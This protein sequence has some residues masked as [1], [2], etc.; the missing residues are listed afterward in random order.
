MYSNSI[1]I[2]TDFYATCSCSPI[3]IFLCTVLV[4][5][6]RLGQISLSF[7]WF[8]NLAA[9]THT[10]TYML[11]DQPFLIDSTTFLSQCNHMTFNLLPIFMMCDLCHF[12][13]HPVGIPGG[14]SYLFCGRA[15]WEREVSTSSEYNQFCDVWRV[16]GGG[17]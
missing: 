3:Y 6:P 2:G 8:Q 17:G 16:W 15:W 14:Q 4:T 9:S 11:D 10:N 7:W 13:T 1:K 5:L 12:V